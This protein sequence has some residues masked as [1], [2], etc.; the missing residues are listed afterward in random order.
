M[1]DLKAFNYLRTKF[2]QKSKKYKRLTIPTLT[3]KYRQRITSSLKNVLLL[4]SIL[5][6]SQVSIQ[7]KVA[8]GIIQRIQE[9]QEETKYRSIGD[10]N[11]TASSSIY[12]QLRRSAPRRTEL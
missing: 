10:T 8:T 2:L 1:L 6:S 3:L 5:G 11:R 7:S 12:N 4:R 9:A